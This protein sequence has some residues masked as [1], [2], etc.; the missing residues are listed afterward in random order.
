M[1][2]VAV[3]VLGTTLIRTTLLNVTSV[4]TLPRMQLSACVGTSSGKCSSPTHQPEH[5]L[6]DPIKTSDVYS[7]RGGTM[8]LV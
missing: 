7:S 5:H 1:A 4:W 8:G 6:S 3:M 2:A